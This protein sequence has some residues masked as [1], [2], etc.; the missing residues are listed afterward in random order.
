MAV[1]PTKTLNNLKTWLSQELNE[2]PQYDHA[3][4]FTGYEHI[5]LSNSWKLVL[6][7]QCQVL[8]ISAVTLLGILMLQLSA[9]ECKRSEYC[10]YWHQLGNDDIH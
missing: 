1:D 9:G 5:S 7:H 2:L 10:R 3:M 8:Y 6:V 4:A